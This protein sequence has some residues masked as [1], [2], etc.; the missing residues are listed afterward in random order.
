MGAEANLEI[1]LRPAEWKENE[2]PQP[3]SGGRDFRAQM[4]IEVRPSSLWNSSKAFGYLPLRASEEGDEEHY[5]SS[6]SLSL[7]PPTPA[8][9]KA[10]AVFFFFFVLSVWPRKKLFF[11]IFIFETFLGFLKLFF[12]KLLFIRLFNS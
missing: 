5:V 11:S 4:Q 12:P 10:G 7:S 8:R 6:L 3:Q 2:L 1:K 9:E